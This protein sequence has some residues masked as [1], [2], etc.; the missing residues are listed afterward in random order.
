MPYF[1]ICFIVEFYFILVNYFLLSVM[2]G[3]EVSLRIVNV[4][5]VHFRFLNI[6]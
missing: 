4:F 6:N 2:S 1:T 3:K 5:F